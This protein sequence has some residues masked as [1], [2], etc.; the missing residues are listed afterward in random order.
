MNV[1][2]ETE[3]FCND[4]REMVDA[5]PV[6]VDLWSLPVALNALLNK[7]SDVRRAVE[8]IHILQES[9]GKFQVTYTS[10][11]SNPEEPM[12]VVEVGNLLFEASL[13][14][15]GSLYDSSVKEWAISMYYF[16]D[17]FRLPIFE[18]LI[19]LCNP[20]RF[21]QTYI[22]MLF[23]NDAN[24]LAYEADF[25]KKKFKNISEH[26]VRRLRT[27]IAGAD[28]HSREALVAITYLHQYERTYQKHL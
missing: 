6:E 21:I 9:L 25:L 19:T 3:S 12:A 20:E 24:R 7:W 13:V 1:H 28:N 22:A 14:I 23:H 18:E 10:R 17:D 8:N 2:K 16:Q 27:A 15:G 26:F 11:H 4:F 5:L